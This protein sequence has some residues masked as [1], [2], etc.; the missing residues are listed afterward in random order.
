MDEIRWEDPPP[1]ATGSGSRVWV[2]KLAP[3]REHPKRWASVAIFPTSSQAANAAG[4]L[5]GGHY[6]RGP[7]R[8]EFAA[9]TVEGEHHVYARYLGPDENGGAL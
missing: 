9:R 4:A 6:H 7:G 2:T 1:K 5:R 3:L 8:W